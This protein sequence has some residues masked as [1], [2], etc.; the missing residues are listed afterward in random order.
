MREYQERGGEEYNK[1]SGTTNVKEIWKVLGLKEED[2][3]DRTKLNGEIQ[4]H[5]GDPR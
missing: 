2:A 1:P 5:S 3:L 4:H